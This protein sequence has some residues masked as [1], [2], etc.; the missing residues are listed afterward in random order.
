LEQSRT[1][2][3]LFCRKTQQDTTKALVHTN[4][5]GFAG[6]ANSNIGKASGNGIEVSLDYSKS[7]NKDLWM[8]VR[9]KFTYA[10]SKYDV[11][12]E[13][14]YETTPWRSHKNR[15]ISQTYGYIAERLFVDEEEVRN[16]PEQTFGEYGAGDIKYKDINGDM[17]I[18]E[19]DKDGTISNIYVQEFY[20]Y[21]LPS[22]MTFSLGVEAKLS[23]WK[24]W[25]RETPDYEDLNQRRFEL[26]GCTS[27]KTGLEPAGWSTSLY[28]PNGYWSDKPYTNYWWEEWRN[29]WVLLGDYY[30]AKPSGQAVETAEDLA[31]AR[32]GHDMLVPLDKPAVKFL[33]LVVKETGT[34]QSTTMFAELSFFG[35]DGEH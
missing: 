14:D 10:S 17:V 26:W 11:Y 3:R 21:P 9:G 30:I 12:E 34:G 20:D 4:N 19:N 33:R 23:R 27:Y 16:S 31:V 15:K 25:W 24:M 18:D 13:P 8:T 29:D 22:M 35:D 2:G 28:P 6:T 7:F 1:A 32:A 5:D